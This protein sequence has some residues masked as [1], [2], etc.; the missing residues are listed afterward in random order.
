MRKT[1][2]WVMVIATALAVNLMFAQVSLAQVKSQVPGSTNSAGAWAF[3]VPGLIHTGLEGTEAI[4]VESGKVKKVEDMSGVKDGLQVKFVSDQGNGYI[5]YMGPKWFMNNQ[6][7]KFMAGDQ[8]QV[9]GKKVGSSIIATEISKGE[10]TMK[11]RN[12]EDGM[13]TW[14]CC[15]PREVKKLQ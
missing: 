13:P 14:E 2:I 11:L 7:L 1:A 12:E 3:G 9:R 8:V 5:V 10:W 6:K 15:F 4:V